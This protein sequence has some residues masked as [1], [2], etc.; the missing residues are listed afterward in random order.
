LN[1]A[2]K[3]ITSKDETIDALVNHINAKRVANKGNKLV[4]F[5]PI[6]M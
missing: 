6:L 1:K 4:V 3:S 5:I 2:I